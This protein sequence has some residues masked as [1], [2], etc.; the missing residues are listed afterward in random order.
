MRLSPVSQR[1]LVAR[2]RQLGWTGPKYQGK[3]PYMLIEGKPPLKIPNPH[4]EDISVDL[5]KRILRQAKIS[6]EEWLRNS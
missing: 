6:R 4:S 5:L 2:L 1:E 3:H